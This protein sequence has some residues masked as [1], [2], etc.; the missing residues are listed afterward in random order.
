MFGKKHHH[1]VT[2]N[3]PVKSHAIF[4][5]L[6]KMPRGSDVF[7]YQGKMSNPDEALQYA[8]KQAAVNLQVLFAGHRMAHE[9]SR[10]DL[11]GVQPGWFA[12]FFHSRTR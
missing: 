3:L 7:E 5:Y 10:E 2:P 9:A 4:V 8:R 12:R 11:D 6:E 1:L